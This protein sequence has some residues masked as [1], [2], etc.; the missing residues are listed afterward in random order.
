MYSPSSC[1]TL[2][3]LMPKTNVN[4]SVH[5]KQGI[6]HTVSKI[7]AATAPLVLC[8]Q[9]VA[10]P[11]Q[12]AEPTVL[13]QKPAAVQQTD[14]TISVPSTVALVFI[15][16]KVSS[17]SAPTVEDTAVAVQ[18]AS[19]SEQSTTIAKSAPVNRPT[20]T[21][22]AP[23]QTTAPAYTQPAAVQA[24][25]AGFGATIVAAAL[26]QLGVHQDCTALVS[27]SIAAVGI[28]FHGWP[29]GYLSLGRTVSAAEAQPGDLIYYGNAGAGVPHIAVY[30][31]GGMAVHGGWN[32]ENTAV[33]SAYLGSG[34][35]FI[36]L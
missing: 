12:A 22:P 35:V 13:P 18:P 29:A 6:M 19:Q 21:T 31:G 20:N 3:S 14:P 33:A 10:G 26:A 8:A 36:R 17:T 25:P 34:P 2:D 7:L 11:A 24:P 23:V 15:Q 30:I 9:L 27:N 16:S 4:E 1:Y 32:G 28:H 5:T